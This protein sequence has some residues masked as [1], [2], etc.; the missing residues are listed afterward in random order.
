MEALHGGCLGATG[1]DARTLNQLSR[2]LNDLLYFVKYYCVARVR[3]YSLGL[4][5]SDVVSITVS[6]HIDISLGETSRDPNAV[7]RGSLKKI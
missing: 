2:H 7:V 5:V 4:S 3:I 6:E 1:V